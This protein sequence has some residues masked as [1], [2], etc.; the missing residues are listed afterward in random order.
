LWLGMCLT[1]LLGQGGG[2]E[3]DQE[4]QENCFHGSLALR[5]S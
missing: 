3:D 5:K 1:F 2:G 4:Q